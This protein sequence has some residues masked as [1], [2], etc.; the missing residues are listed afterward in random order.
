METTWISSKFEAPMKR[1]LRSLLPSD[2]QVYIITMHHACNIDS[3]HDWNIW[4]TEKRMKY[5]RPVN[6]WTLQLNPASEDGALSLGKVKVR[7]IKGDASFPLERNSWWG[8][9]HGKGWPIK[10]LPTVL[11]ECTRWVWSGS[12]SNDRRLWPSGP[13]VS[14]DWQD[15]KSMLWSWWWALSS[16][17][18]KD[19]RILLSLHR[20][21]VHSTL[22]KQPTQMVV[23]GQQCPSLTKPKP[24][25]CPQHKTKG[26]FPKRVSNMRGD[27]SQSVRWMHNPLGKERLSCTEGHWAAPRW[28]QGHDISSE[29]T[30]SRQS[31]KWEP[32]CQEAY[33]LWRRAHSNSN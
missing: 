10:H 2:P 26:D 25:F 6:M 27:R 4:V 7:E 19:R 5:S 24:A 33:E 18:D 31:A 20:T 1:L 14:A 30:G 16:N 8:G 12:W 11:H 29:L 21:R 17:G 23:T 9:A 32:H 3:M 13:K 28:G 22:R 15:M